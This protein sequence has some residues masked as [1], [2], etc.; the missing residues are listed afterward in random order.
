MASIVKRKSKYAV[1][2]TAPDELGNKKQ[3]WETFASM[4]D[5]KKRKKAI[6]DLI[7]KGSFIVPTVKTLKELLDEYISVYGINTWA[8]STYEGN[9]GLIDN[10]INPII[11]KLPLTEINPRMMNKYYQDLL[12]IK[13]KMSAN[14]SYKRNEYVSPET[15]RSIHKVL[16]S[17][18]NQ[19]VKWELLD[20]NPVVN[21]V[22]PKR[23]E[24][25]RDIWD[26]GTL[27]KA[28]DLCKE[29]ILALSMNLAFSCSLRMGEL[30]GLTWDC[31]DISEDSIRNN[32][33]YI[34]VNK[35]LQRISKNAMEALSGNDIIYRFPAIYPKNTTVLVLKPPKTKT[36]VRKIYLPK[37]VAEMLIERKKEIDDLKE[38][39]GEEYS[40]Y[41]LVICSANGRPMEGSV[42]TRMFQKLI[43]ENGLPRVVFHS[44]RHTSTTY[45]LKLSGGDI[46]SVQGDTG[47]A[48]ATMVT[49]RYAHIMDD[50]RR[51]NAERLEEAFYGGKSTK[52]EAPPP[53]DSSLSDESIELAKAIGNSPE[54]MALL[55]GLL[56]NNN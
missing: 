47:H 41:D 48:Q 31:V 19:A 27:C 12:T 33:A 45:K 14:Y 13:V 39:F 6:E 17:A 3:H 35:E 55:K 29:P 10:Y 51:L 16:R 1:V 23:E 18:L 7:E 34:Y 11:E 15:V 22:L 40:D 43:R 32:R 37:T 5:A 42:I 54:L 53:E 4:A 56:K 24:K 20:H 9:K 25:H 52:R 36:S 49:D 38:V 28:I 21:C 50:D 8:A 30:L 44:L 46:K 26:A 2:Y